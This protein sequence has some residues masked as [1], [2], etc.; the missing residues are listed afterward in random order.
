VGCRSSWSLAWRVPYLGIPYQNAKMKM[1]CQFGF[2]QSN[3]QLLPSRCS[4]LCIHFLRESYPVTCQTKIFCCDMLSRGSFDATVT[5]LP[6][7]SLIS[8]ELS[9]HDMRG[10]S[11]RVQ[12]RPE[13]RGLAME[14]ETGS[15]AGF[16]SAACVCCVFRWESSGSYRNLI[17]PQQRR[18][19]LFP[20]TRSWVIGS[21]P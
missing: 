18:P 16:E 21:M 14:T 3:H 11:C 7:T 6:R 15:A 12:Q 4:R 8:S 5:C 20:K 2:L 1:M 17:T 10:N 13:A 9:L 19:R